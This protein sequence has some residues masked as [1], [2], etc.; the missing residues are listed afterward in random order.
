MR[1]MLVD[2]VLTTGS[3]VEACADAL[4]AAGAVEV[5]AVTVARQTADDLNNDRVR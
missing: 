2:D 1:L 4:V 3:T 5:N